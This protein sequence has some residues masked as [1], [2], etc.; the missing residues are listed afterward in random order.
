MTDG[1]TDRRTDRRT[2]GRTDGGDCNI[3]IA[4][5]KKRGDNDF[6]EFKVHLIHRKQVTLLHNTVWILYDGGP[7]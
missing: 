3:P 1:R 6:A 5:L 7:G 2:D 4:F